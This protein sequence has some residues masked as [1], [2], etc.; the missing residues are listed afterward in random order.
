MGSKYEEKNYMDQ[1]YFFFDKLDF[2]VFYHE[3]YFVTS[4]DVDN[5][6]FCDVNLT[7]FGF[8]NFVLKI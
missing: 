4:H 5:L 6:F 8:Y 2:V 1:L 3:K 7:T